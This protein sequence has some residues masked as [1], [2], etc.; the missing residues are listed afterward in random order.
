MTEASNTTVEPLNTI[1]HDTPRVDAVERVTG[2]AKYSRDVKLPGML[3]GRV[4]RSPHPH[5]R[6]LSID[7]SEASRLPGVRAIITHENA[8]I[9]WGAGSISGG[10][11]YNDPAKAATAHR[12]YI[13]NNPVR[14]VG[15]SVAAVAATDRHIAEEALTLIRVQYEELP[16]VLEPEAALADGAPAIWPE[17]NLCPDFRNNFEPMVSDIGDI[18][19]GFAEADQVFEERYETGFIHNAQMEPRCALASWEGGKLTLYTPSQGISNC[20]HDTA[21][22]LGLEDH[23]VRIVCHYMGGGFGNKNQNQDADLVAA[24]LSK[25]AAAPVMLEFSRREDWLGVHGRWP[26]VQ[27]YKVGVKNDGTVTAIQMR[28]YSGMGPYRK[29]SGGIGGMDAY[30]C[31]NRQRTIYPVYTNRTTSGNFRAPSEP[32][33]FYGIES[34]MDD[35]AHQLGIDPVEFTLKNMRRPTEDRPYTN[36]SLDECIALGAEQFDWQSRRQVTPGSDDGSI[37][38]GAGFSFMM[39]RAGVGTSSAIIRVDANA[40]Y[41]LFVGV[42]DIGPGAKTTMGMIAAEA[43]AVP[44]SQLEVV[45]GDTD[46]C[47]YSVGESGSRTTIMTGYA[48]VEA[49]KDLIQQIAAKGMPSGDGILIASATPRPTTDGKIRQCFAAHFTEVEVDTRIGSTRVVKY[50]AVHESGRIINPQTARDQIRGAVI[51]GIGQ[52]LHENLLYDPASGQPLTTGYYRARHLTHLDIPDI[53][54]SFIEVD[55]GYGP[56][57]AKTAGESGIILAP[58]AVANAIFNATGKRMTS[59]PITRDKILGAMA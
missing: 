11:Q 48:V 7:I 14:F 5:A 41:T 38:R 50:V 22:D 31:P 58:A 44:M 10:R 28:G 12:R 9:V 19:A 57:G 53:E 40:H 39:F 20:R 25:H 46:R 59:L 29:N 18:D 55:D 47:P 37:K 4:L 33:G 6:I 32:H 52:A 13:F 45:S 30:A 54:V 21:R 24:T 16:F 3:Y 56:F 23:Q 2:E 49:A 15:D 51:Q 36:Y 26:T 8:P 1:G 17:G 35:I 42:T 43:L 34:M 27:Y